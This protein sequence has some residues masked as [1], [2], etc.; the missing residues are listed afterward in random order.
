MPS[1][2]S[3]LSMRDDVERAVLEGDAVRLLQAFG[4][5]LVL[6]LAVLVGDGIDLADGARADEDRALVAAR[7]HARAGHAVRP[8]LDLEAGRHLELVDRDL[9]ERRHRHRRGVRGASLELAMLDGMPLLPRR[10]W[11]GG[12]CA[13]SS[14]AWPRNSARQADAGGELRGGNATRLHVGVS[15]LIYACRKGRHA[16][17]LVRQRYDTRGRR[18]SANVSITRAA[19]GLRKMNSRRR[20]CR[21]LLRRRARTLRDS[22]DLAQAGSVRSASPAKARAWQ[23]QPPQSTSRNSQERQGS[24]IQPVPRKRWK[25]SELSQMSRRRPVAHVVEDEAGNGLGG[26]AGQYLARRRDVEDAAAPA[27]H[28]GLGPAG[29]VVG[30]HEVDDEHALQALARALDQLGAAQH[31]LARRHQGLRGCCS[32]Q[33]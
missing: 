3:A 18:G 15:R 9:L 27:A 4:D 8:D 22:E 2:R 13:L 7:H 29:V 12:C 26:V 30:H 31:L 10:R 24:R 19:R 11:R 21:L 14:K 1:K 23:R 28:A 20:Q 25:A 33:P 5:H 6:A 17:A 32:A 16:I